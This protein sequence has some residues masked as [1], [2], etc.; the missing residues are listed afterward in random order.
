M[1]LNKLDD[2]PIFPI[3]TAA[4]LLKISIPTLRLYEKEGLIIPHKTNSNQRAYSKH[5]LERIECIRKSIKKSKISI[6]GIKAMLAMIPCWQIIGCSDLDRDNCI[7]YS[8]SSK[9]CWAHKHD[10][11]VCATNECR[12]CTV[13]KDFSECSKVKETIQNIGK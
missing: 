7:S 5:D 2:K 12:E 11:G 6:N 3:R 4:E 10:N 8:D 13:Y 9:P 1:D